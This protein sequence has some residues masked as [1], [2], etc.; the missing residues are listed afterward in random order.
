MILGAQATDAHGQICI[1][2]E[3]NISETTPFKTL[4]AIDHTVALRWWTVLRRSPR[5]SSTR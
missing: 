4:T 1:E 2:D 3:T 5:S